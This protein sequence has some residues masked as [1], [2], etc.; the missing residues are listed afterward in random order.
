MYKINIY[1]LKLRH[2]GLTVGADC[3]NNGFE[4]HSSQGCLS[5]SFRVAL[6]YSCDALVRKGQ[7]SARA[8]TQ[9]NLT[10]IIS[11]HVFGVP[12]VTTF[13]CDVVKCARDLGER[14]RGT[15]FVQNLDT[16]QYLHLR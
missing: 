13:V 10:G 8:R 6:S 11:L 4:S 15:G 12:P 1:A 5:A 7:S 14:K 2:S 9:A 3:S 16:I